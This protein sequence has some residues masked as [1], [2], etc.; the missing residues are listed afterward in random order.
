M[1]FDGY[2]FAITGASSGIGRATAILLGREGASLGLIGTNQPR[3]EAAREEVL[4]A[5]APAAVIEQLDVRDLEAME[6][7]AESLAGELGS[8]DGL[9]HSAGINSPTSLE[10]TPLEVWR[11]VIDVNL[12]GAFVACKA[13]FPLV[14]QSA[15]G[16]IV[17]L[18]SV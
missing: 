1:R 6:R 9:V 7:V 3:L 17:L 10:A 16:S 12:T 11:E 5:G 8:I 18:S 15:R 4:A 2:G 14:R 13:F